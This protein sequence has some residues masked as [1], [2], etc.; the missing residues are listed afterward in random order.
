MQIIE[1][2]FHLIPRRCH[3]RLPSRY[4]RKRR[5]RRIP[6]RKRDD[7]AKENE[8]GQYGFFNIRNPHGKKGLGTALDFHPNGG[9]MKMVKLPRSL[10]RGS[11]FR[12]FFT[13]YFNAESARRFLLGGKGSTPTSRMPFHPIP[14]TR[15]GT[16]ENILDARDGKNDPV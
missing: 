1:V 9:P 4:W 3:E 13:R 16:F 14:E 2:F 12:K 11:E 6:N 10:L 7:R 5:I 8:P 15:K